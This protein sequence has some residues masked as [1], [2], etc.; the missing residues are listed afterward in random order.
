MVSFARALGVRGEA[1]AA[2]TRV[3]ATRPF[4]LNEPNPFSVTPKRSDMENL[5]QKAGF[6]KTPKR[7]DMEI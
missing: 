3:D 6:K 5:T 1:R 7:S 2:M 4:P